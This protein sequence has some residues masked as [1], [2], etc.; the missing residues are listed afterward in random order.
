M[1]KDIALVT[2]LGS[3]NDVLFSKNSECTYTQNMPCSYHLNYCELLVA[4]EIF[5]STPELL[6]MTISSV[7]NR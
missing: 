1:L 6:N 4:N 5:H 3:A 7:R 2:L